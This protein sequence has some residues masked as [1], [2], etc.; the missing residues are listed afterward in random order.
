MT[1]A[2][3]WSDIDIS[4]RVRGAML[5]K[6]TTLSPGI[7]RGSAYVITSATRR[8]APQRQIERADVPNE[9]RRFD[10]ALAQAEADLRA[11][12]QTLQAE[13]GAR[14]AAIFAAQAL[15][16]RDSG[17]R[18]EVAAI[19]RDR[20]LNIE[21]ALSEV[22]ER[23]MRTF[24][25]VADVYLRERATDIRDVGRRV[26]DV[27][28]SGQVADTCT[29]PDG[30]IIVADELLPSAA[31]RLEFNRVKAFVTEH[32]GRFS[33][34]AILARSLGT[35]AVA[36]VST[37]GDKIKTGDRLIVDG[38]SG[39]VFVNPEPS[40]EREYERLEA[41][42]RASKEAL[43]TLIDVPSVTLDGIHI[44]LLA[45]VSKF[46][47][48]ESALLSNAEGIGLYRTETCS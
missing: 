41:E 22:I 25:K 43:R 7:S 9:L 18:D 31:A 8:V 12:E 24:D 32:G 28:L 2:A 6:G 14:E 37:I 4:D 46:P 42:I 23:Y 20:Q 5:L 1:V 19:V 11:L 33:H 3:H 35:P 26:L 13:I 48:T 39:V 30:A 45:T 36:G 15:L 29:I 34:T 38:V 16:V 17:F 21:A 47:D 44:Q 27:L 10:D 40:I